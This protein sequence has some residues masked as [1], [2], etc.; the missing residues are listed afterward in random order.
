MKIFNKHS[1]IG[2]KLINIKHLIE[3]GLIRSVFFILRFF[4]IEKASD[5]CANFFG[6]FGKYSKA[7]SSILRNLSMIYAD[8]TDSEKEGMAM[9][10]WRNSGRYVG[11]LAFLQNL[12]IKCAIANGV[13]DNTDNAHITIN[14][15]QNMVGDEPKLFFVGHIANWEIML[16]VLSKHV[17]KLAVVYRHANNP[18]VDKLLCNYR[19][20]NNVLLIEK[21]N[22]GARA[23]L[24]AIRDGYSI[25]MLLDQ[26][27]NE[28]VAVDFM[29]REA[30]TAPAIAIFAERFN[31]P[32][33]PIQM[34]R[35]NNTVMFDIIIYPKFFVKDV[36]N[37][38]EYAH[39][40][41]ATLACLMYINK[42]Y[43]SWI[44]ENPDQ[45]FWQ[46]QRWGK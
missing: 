45:W 36:Q 21:G 32:I 35:K 46:H 12:P 15:L 13:T 3:Y 26:K 7:N 37:M 18:Y 17:K 28:G 25:A 2:G 23:L 6:R 8:M 29:G 1:L 22:R 38:H 10:I 24:S 30:M 41:D 11:E 34:I 20:S 31:M 33:I 39:I 5:I 14:G 9:R 40:S 44:N 4:T 16:N 43:S 27:M 42:H 19:A